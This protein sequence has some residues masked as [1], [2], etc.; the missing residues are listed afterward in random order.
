MQQSTYDIAII[1]GGL[2]GLTQAILLGLNGFD[3]VVVDYSPNRNDKR[4]TAISY[5]S[6][7]ILKQAEIWDDLEPHGCPIEEI[8]IL[9]G[10]S[11][12]LLDFNIH[13]TGIEADAFGWILENKVIFSALQKKIKSTKA[14]T[15][16]NNTKCDDISFNENEAEIILSD[17]TIL[18]AK[19]VIGADG[20]RSFIR[21]KSG[22]ASKKWSYNQTAIV[23]FAQHEKPHNNIAV[24]HFKK[25]GP[26]AILPMN[27]STNGT[28]QSSIVWTNEGHD[29]SPYLGHHNLLLTAMNERFPDFYGSVTAVSEVQAYPLSF[30][31]AYKYID[32]R[33][34]LIADAAH[35]IHPIAGQGLNIGLQDV[36]AL[37]DH[38]VS[39]KDQ[40]FGLA[41]NL[42]AYEVQS[43]PRNMKMTAA[44]DILNSLFAN[45]ILPISLARKAGL[46][47]IQRINP[48]KSYFAKTA[49]GDL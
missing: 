37:T 16:L 20:R 32:H 6:H 22:I 48:A 44:T 43:I 15:Y 9:D 19:L 21:E 3:T 34:A 29:V 47:L 11:P 4:T 31:H 38:L 40:D 41:D 10:K 17:Q 45:N 2:S 36:K 27:D 49:M 8:Q 23:C 26:F 7:K 33:C 13:D 12:V 18:K 42:K 25:S 39:V 1:G 14:V 35:G 30:N 5:G 24:E 46:K 28:H